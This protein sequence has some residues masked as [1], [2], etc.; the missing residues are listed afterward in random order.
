MDIKTINK[1][2]KKGRLKTNEEKIRCIY[3]A[4]DSIKELRIFT[5]EVMFSKSTGL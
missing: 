2:L 3:T 4:A 1:E 5:R